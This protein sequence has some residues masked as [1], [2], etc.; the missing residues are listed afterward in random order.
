[1]AALTESERRAWQRE[2]DQEQERR[3]I[4]RTQPVTPATPVK[5]RGTT[6]RGLPRR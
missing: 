6:Q 4:A 2:Y 3:R 1:M 5:S